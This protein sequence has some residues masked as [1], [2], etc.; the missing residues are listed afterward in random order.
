MYYI[1]ISSGIPSIHKILASLNPNHNFTF[2]HARFV[3]NKH[4][5]N[6]DIYSYTMIN[7]LQEF[8]IALGIYM[9]RN[10]SEHSW[11]ASSL[12]RLAH[13]IHG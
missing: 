3:S 5:L 11:E 12:V 8:T 9:W 2:S 13:I 6:H 7:N 10:T 1:Y 4:S